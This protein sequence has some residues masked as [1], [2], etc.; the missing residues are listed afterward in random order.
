MV[1]YVCS[2]TPSPSRTR[3]LSTWL[4]SASPRTQR[5]PVQWA[6]H[7]PAPAPCERAPLSGPASLDAAP[8][9]PYPPALDG[10]AAVRT[11]PWTAGAPRAE[12]PTSTEST[13][14][15]RPSRVICRRRCRARWMRAE[16]HDKV[17]LSLRC[18][19]PRSAS[20]GRRRSRSSLC[21]APGRIPLVKSRLLRRDQK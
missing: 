9:P 1:S 13:K 18:S 16:Q 7:W 20:R 14:Q 4:P 21:F 15:K 10:A 2:R 3:R 17:P 11:A 5:V 12:C 19:A 8:S 6:A